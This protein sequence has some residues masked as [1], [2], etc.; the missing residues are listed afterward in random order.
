[1]SAVLTA[2]QVAQSQ[3]T[4]LAVDDERVAPKV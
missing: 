4:V 2:S 3:W 1:M